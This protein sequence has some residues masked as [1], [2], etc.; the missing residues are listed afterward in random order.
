M[1]MGYIHN[2][3]SRFGH[4]MLLKKLRKFLLINELTYAFLLVALFL[5][6]NNQIILVANKISQYISNKSTVIFIF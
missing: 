5:C 6:K 2:L 4:D 3:H 1:N